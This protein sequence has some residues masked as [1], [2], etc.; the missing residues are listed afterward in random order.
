MAS[1]KERGSS[2]STY[3]ADMTFA[4]KMLLIFSLI[5]FDYP[6]WARHNQQNN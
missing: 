5:G 6:L 3:V 1:F 4:F 2:D